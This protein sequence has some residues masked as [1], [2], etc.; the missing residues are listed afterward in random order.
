MQILYAGAQLELNDY[1]E[2]YE[3]LMSERVAIFKRLQEL[4]ERRLRIKDEGALQIVKE[5]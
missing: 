5:M 1:K 3:V 4:E 2:K